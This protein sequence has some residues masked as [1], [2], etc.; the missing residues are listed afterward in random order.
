M[1]CF[2]IEAVQT[3]QWC[4]ETANSQRRN[5]FLNTTSLFIFHQIN[6][7]F[8]IKLDV[9]QKDWLMNSGWQSQKENIILIHGYAG[10]EETPPVGVLIDGNTEFFFFPQLNKE[11][12]L[13]V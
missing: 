13:F 8:S 2:C 7:L 12:E 5:K 11:I 10:G 4:F 3:L 9:T 6:F 1:C